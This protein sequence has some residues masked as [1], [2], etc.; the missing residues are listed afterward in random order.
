MN[1]EKHSGNP[2]KKSIMC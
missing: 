2:R 1:H